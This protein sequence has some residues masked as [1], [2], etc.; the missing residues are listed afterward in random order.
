MSSKQRK[1]LPIGG[2]FSI[3]NVNAFITNTSYEIDSLVDIEIM[4]YFLKKNS[5]LIESLFN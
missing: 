1:D 3:N 4:E 2:V 5:K